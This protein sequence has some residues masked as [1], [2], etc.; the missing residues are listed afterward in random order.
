V[1]GRVIEVDEF[2]I[3]LTADLFQHTVEFFDIHYHTGTR[4][5]ATAK[6]YSENI[7]VSVAK[8]THAF[9]K[10]AMIFFI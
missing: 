8:G 3:E 5:H 4:I 1:K 2:M 9:P 7:I 10:S 6:R